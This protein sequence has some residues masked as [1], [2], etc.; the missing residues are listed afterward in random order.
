MFDKSGLENFPQKILKLS[1][2]YT[3]YTND[4][5]LLLNSSD[6][7]PT[8]QDGHPRHTLHSQCGVDHHSVQDH[9][10]VLVLGH[11]RH[12]GHLLSLHTIVSSSLYRRRVDVNRMINHQVIL[13]GMQPYFD[14]T[15]DDLKKN[16]KLK[17]TSTKMKT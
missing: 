7:G 17:K 5:V 16:N 8:W 15:E 14:T 11:Q 2:R 1:S 3:N 10:P 13:P 9:L 4:G 12:T 6:Q